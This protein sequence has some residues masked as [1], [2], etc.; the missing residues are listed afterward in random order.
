LQPE[1]RRAALREGVVFFVGAGSSMTMQY[2]PVIIAERLQAATTAGLLFG[3]VQA[4]APL[5]LLSRV[6]GAVM[7][8]ALAG[9]TE[10]ERAQAHVD[11][12][13]PFFV[14]TLAIA[15]GI[16]PWVVLSLGIPPIGAAVSVGA[17]VALI[18]LMQVWA[19]P[20]VTVLSARKRELVPA[21]ASLGGLV[22]ASLVWM[23]GVYT[24]E[25]ILLPV[26]L[27]LGAVIRSLV[28]MWVISG[29]LIGRL[30]QERLVVLV[31]AIAITLLMAALSRTS[32]G[33]TLAGGALLAIGGLGVA[34]QIWRRM[35]SS[36]DA[37]SAR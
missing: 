6:Y 15:L 25:V 28:P 3:A 4:T 23:A 32:V 30:D 2:L 16:A 14:A 8:P 26:G 10:A 12:V 20:A 24:G 29:R 36:A 11:M 18:T 31:S 5:L 27:A 7:M 33:I 9:E 17:L 1:E 37:N 13:R 35:D 34:Y 22:V 19:T 21:L